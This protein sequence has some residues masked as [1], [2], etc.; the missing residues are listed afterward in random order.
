MMSSSYVIRLYFDLALQVVK[1]L[2]RIGSEIDTLVQHMGSIWSYLIRPDRL[3][4]NAPKLAQINAWFDET[5]NRRRFLSLVESAKLLL[6]LYINFFWSLPLFLSH[7]QLNNIN[8]H[9]RRRR[10]RRGETASL[11][12]DGALRSLLGAREPPDLIHFQVPL[13]PN[14]SLLPIRL[15]LSMFSSCRCPFRSVARSFLSGFLSLLNL[16]WF[17]SVF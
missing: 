14:A 10:R 5:N 12:G 8:T 13:S 9:R 2:T 7:T 16:C 3:P 1:S 11:H 15:S 17:E 6:R 4:P